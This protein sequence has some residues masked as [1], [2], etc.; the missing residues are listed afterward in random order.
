MSLSEDSDQ[1][2]NICTNSCFSC[3]AWSLL[4]ET[5]VFGVV[6]NSSMQLQRLLQVDPFARANQG[7]KSSVSLI[8]NIPLQIAHA[9]TQI[10][11]GHRS[12]FSE[13]LAPPSPRKKQI[14]HSYD[15]R[16]RIRFDALLCQAYQSSRKLRFYATLR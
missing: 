12:R 9:C 15:A 4:P 11:L 13:Q 8:A 14:L 3:C 6:R 5:A 16:A 10:Y 7:N 1:G 2:P